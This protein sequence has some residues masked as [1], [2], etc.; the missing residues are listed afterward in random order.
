M[1]VNVMSISRFVFTACLLTVFSATSGL[2]AKAPDGVQRKIR[3]GLRTAAPCLPPSASS[4]LDINNIR[5]LLHNGGDMWWDL[6]GDPRYEVPKG[7]NRH[8][9]FAGSLWIGGL[10]KTGQL[11]VAAQT[12]RQSG[13]DFWPGPLIQGPGTTEQETC[14]LFNKMFKIN[15]TEI[16]DFRAEF[17]VNGSIADE[18]KYPNVFNWPTGTGRN[19]QYIDAGG[20]QVSAIRPDGTTIYLAPWV[21]AGGSGNDE[22]TYDPDKGDF[23]DIKGD[24]AIWWVINDRG[25]VHTE[26]G[27]EPIGVEIHMMAFAFTTANAVNN[28][29]FY[30]Q[31]VINRSNL[32]L[33]ETYLGQWA[34]PDLGF[35]RD[36]YVGCDTT[37]GLGICY[38]GD[39]NDEGATGYGLNPP[40]IGIDFFQGP[41]ADPDDGLDNDKDGVTDE[42]GETIIMSKFVYYNNDFSL[43]GNPE[44]ATHYYGY[45]RGFWKDGT[46]IVDNY[47]NGGNGNGYGP[48]SPGDPTNYMFAGNPCAGT[49]WTEKNATNPP[50]DRRLIQSSG[51]FTLQPGAVNT[52]VTGLVWARG[53]YQDEIGSVCELIK[54]DQI[55]QALFDNNFTLLDGPD[56]PEI[57]LTELDRELILSWGYS[58]ASRTVRNN[59]N[60]SYVQADPVLKAQGKPDS[61][62]RFQGYVVYQL[63]D[64]TVGQAEL[65]DPDRARVVAQ[66]DIRDGVGTIVNRTEQAVNG[67]S[68]PI[69]TDQV[70][71]QGADQGIINSVRITEDLF[72]Q[73]DDKRLKNYTNYYYT[74]VAYAYNDSTSD[75]RRFVPGNRYF[76]VVN[77]L[78]HKPEFR[79][80][81]TTLQAAYGD[82]IPVIQTAGRG[83]GG[84]FV[85]ITPETEA[86]IIRA[87][88]VSSKIGFAQGAGPIDVK[89]VD[90]KLVKGSFYQVQV[91]RRKFVR[92]DIRGQDACGTII[93]STFAEWELY[94]GPSVDGPF[95]NPPIYQA[96]YIIRKGGCFVDPPR[97][98]PLVGTERVILG[99]GIS[100]S[101][102]NVIAAGDTLD[103]EGNTGAIGGR[104]SFADAS[105]RWLSGLL[106]QNDLAGGVWNWNMG[107]ASV[108]DGRGGP[109]VRAFKRFRLYDRNEHFT[110]LA[111]GWAPFSFARPFVN[112]S[113]SGGAIGPGIN[114]GPS[115]T[116]RQL[117]A[118]DFLT[119]NELPDVDIVFTSDVT[120]WSRCMVVETSPSTELG[121][122]AWNLSGKWS[123]NILNASEIGRPSPQTTPKTPEV[124]GFS[125]FPGYAINVTT[126]ERLN[127]FFGESTWDVL[128]RGNDMIWNPTSDLG[129]NLDRV[130]GRHYV[131]VS[132]TRY[133]EFESL[134]AAL[135]NA[136]EKPAGG[137]SFSDAIGGFPNGKTLADVYRNVSWVGIPLLSTQFPNI[138]NPTQFPTDARVSLR[139]NQ[140][141]SS[142]PS[143]SDV[144][145]FVFDTNP[146]AAKTEQVEVAKREMDNILVVPNPY[147]GYSDYEGGQLVTTVKLTHLPRRC[148]IS[149]YTL[150]G[151]LVRTYDKDSDVPEQTWDLKNHVGVPVASGVY[152]IHINGFDLGEKVV[153]LMAVMR[154]V[155]LNSF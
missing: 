99:H 2:M 7:S 126:G 25:D 103:V 4:Q 120:K 15:K 96:T 9:M 90:P 116:N 19:S 128:N 18:S 98:A 89:I 112:N 79:E 22:F 142:R 53:F 111:Q 40:A 118:P 12:Y 42:E 88:Y 39:N 8:S 95:N 152:L 154:R 32:T 74:V 3:T 104:I 133:D 45:L 139:V 23:P 47:S 109:P 44:I 35:Y 49:G 52:V 125:W 122:G 64:Q 31:T 145:T 65:S 84:K 56:A 27:G 108:A 110:N 61:L 151:H 71:V 54:A 41:L 93:D 60:E 37:I 106:D 26:T 33:T 1:S 66:C 16:D 5:T 146:Y 55:A 48:S 30:E 14:D 72:G 36:D 138:A 17:S 101:V 147:Y 92:R 6:V 141:F 28:M 59:Y 136:A 114:C 20:N 130:G 134:K 78:P 43:T 82:G 143:A 80:R 150:N 10:D 117:A 144:A 91:T 70:M 51:P 21:E 50:A 38:N 11:R 102:R 107:G 123:D 127:I 29:T 94:E 132:N 153:K 76:R 148:K 69:I 58:E 73:G 155:D 57:A 62:F 129:R 113:Q 119:L 77:A 83:N 115:T 137:G 24:Q 131:Y 81:G 87:P 85:E 149:I 124:H 34:D 75:G 68:E 67:L 140:P 100:I 46:P 105:K 121:S 86:E 63:A 97:P 13:Y 135:T